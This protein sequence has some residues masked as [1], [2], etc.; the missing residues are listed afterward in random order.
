[1]SLKNEKFHF[2]VQFLLNDW[3]R[4]MRDFFLVSVFSVF[5][6]LCLS[7]S[8]LPFFFI[9]SSFFFF[10]FFFFFALFRCRFSLFFFFLSFFLFSLVRSLFF[11]FFFLFSLFLFLFFFF[12]L[13]I[14]RCVVFRYCCVRHASCCITV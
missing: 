13:S 2:S 10:F 8:S 3:E 11:F 9:L 5:S 12:F 4:G 6:A 14:L 1:M 7:S